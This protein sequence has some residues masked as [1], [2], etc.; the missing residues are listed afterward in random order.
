MCGRNYIGNDLRQVQIDANVAQAEAICD[1]PM[2]VW[3]CGDSQNIKALVGDIKAD[4]MFSCPPYADLEV[5]SD[6]PADISNM[7]YGEFIGVYKKIIAECYDLL[8]DD[9]FAVW[10]VGEVRDKSGN[11]LNFVG[12]TINAFKEAGFNYYNEA[13]LVTPVGSLPLRAGKT[14]RASRKLGKTH[15][16][17]LVFVKGSG[18]KA[19]ERCGDIEIHIESDD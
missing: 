10:T 1:E 3:T 5:Y 14:M 4:L 6:D 12:D 17:V 11:Y 9:S 13:I 2:P 15:Q 19:A 8:A 16:N 7:A 18:K